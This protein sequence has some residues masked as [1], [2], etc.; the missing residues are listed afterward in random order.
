MAPNESDSEAEEHP[1]STPRE[2]V[3]QT[4]GIFSTSSRINFRIH[5]GGSQSPIVFYVNNSIF[6]PSTPDVQVM[7]GADK[8]GPIV[9]F[10]KFHNLSGHVTVGLGSPDSDGVV[11]EELHKVSQLVHS[12]YVFESDQATPDKRR[13]KYIWRR[14]IGKGLFA[15]YAC[16]DAENGRMMAYF[17]K[18][19]MRSAK[20]VGR[21]CVTAETTDQFHLLL[22]VS[23]LA[24]R[25]KENR[26]AWYVGGWVSGTT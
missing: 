20:K 23:W 1:G 15:N 2:A 4:Y 6:T 21:L 9:A 19:G 16:V 25:E 7:R 10:G 12:E 18:T 8:N 13:A 14:T 11:F 17:V 22:L 5:A 3:R 26:N 24:I